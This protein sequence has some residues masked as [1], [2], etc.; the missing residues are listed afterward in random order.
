MKEKFTKL[1]GA[2]MLVAL[3][4]GLVMPFQTAAA[5]AE[6]PG[7]II[8][9]VTANDGVNAA[10]VDLEIT[11]NVAVAAP[12]APSTATTPVAY[13]N[14]YRSF[15]ESGT[16]T[17]LANNLVPQV[18]VAN[19]TI[20]PFTDGT[21]IP[22]TVYWYWVEACD[23]SSCSAMGGNDGWAAVTDATGGAPAVSAGLYY[24]HVDVNITGGAAL[25]VVGGY[26]KIQRAKT[27]TAIGAAGW[28]TI[29]QATTLYFK[30]TT[31][32]G[33]APTTDPAA[34]VPQFDYIV[35]TCGTNKCASQNATPVAPT[36][37]TGYLK[38]VVM[39]GSFLATAGIKKVTVT[40]TSS[41]G[42]TSYYGQRAFGSQLLPATPLAIPATTSPETVAT[43]PYTK[44]DTTAVPGNW[45]TYYLWA[46]ATP[47]NCSIKAVDTEGADAA[48][49]VPSDFKVSKGDDSTAP[50]TG[51]DISF[52]A[53]ALTGATYPLFTLYRSDDSAGLVN[54]V[55]LGIPLVT[56]GAG[57]LY[58]DALVNPGQSY[59]YWLKACLSASNCATS[60]KLEGWAKVPALDPATTSLSS[61]TTGVTATWTALAVP[62]VYYKGWR[63]T[64]N[65]FTGA[66]GPKNIF[67]TG[68]ST[69]T[70]TDPNGTAGVTYWYYIQACVNQGTVA[71]CSAPV[72]GSG[73]KLP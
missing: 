44:D 58:N 46:C 8:P 23:A 12:V 56:P 5:Q 19:T 32:P 20:T 37:S 18:G 30:D 11:V 60:S 65:S 53:P 28:T 7:T 29:A 10:G 21:A 42:A 41:I 38:Q 15:T 4:L 1:F 36:A 33:L 57:F 69:I 70:G 2:L 52:T 62:N 43:V 47:L 27:G 39:P 24:D 9:K 35:D 31:V 49:T 25:P 16:K 66:L 55:P 68:S 61:G 54:V 71:R 45:Y 67:G 17:M 22:G 6:I 40:W 51:V 72:V 26:Y 64:T 14:I 48:V 3:M 63:N 73:M 50:A 13:Y 34:V 59:Y